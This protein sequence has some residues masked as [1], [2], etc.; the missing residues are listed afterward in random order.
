MLMTLLV[1]LIILW[2]FGYIH[3]PALPIPD[4]ALF[5][6]NGHIISL[7]DLLIFF[8]VGTL[9]GVLPGPF[10]YMAFALLFLWVLALFGIIAVTG[11]PNI[12][13]LA[14]I[15]G[16]IGYVLNGRSGNNKL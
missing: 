13:V 8:V 2:F 5:T 14:I 3:I 1:L 15:V 7:W 4:I 10:R 11:L 6:F 12:L 16:L 9:I